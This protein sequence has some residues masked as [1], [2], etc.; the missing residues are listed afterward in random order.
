[1][2]AT[3]A[4]IDDDEIL[5]QILA[6]FS[7]AQKRGE[8]PDIEASCQK[9]P[10]LASELRGLWATAQFAAV[11][12]KTSSSN[13]TIDAPLPKPDD[14]ATFKR[15]P[16]IP[17]YEIV[18][19]L[20]RGGMG[21]V[22]LARQK[23]LNREVSLKIMRDSR[24][25][26]ESDRARFR[27]EAASAARL[28][29]PFIVTMYEVGEWQGLPYLVMEY[30]PGGTLTQRL[31]GKPLLPREAAQIVSQISRG[32]QHAHDLGVLH[33]DLKPSNILMEGLATPKISDFGLAKRLTLTA[34]SI[35]EA[36]T[37]SGAIVGTPG[38]LPPEH[39]T[40]AKTSGPTADVYGLGA[41]LY[42]CLTG[43]PPFRA[44]NP[45]DTLLMVIEQEPTPPR[46]LTPGLDRDLENICLKCLQKNPKLRYR[47]ATDLADDLEAYLAGEQVSSAQSG[48]SYFISRMLRETHHASVLENWGLLW[49]WHALATFVLCFFTQ[50]LEWQ[51]ER[52]HLT[53]LILWGVGLVTWGTILWQ[54]RRRAGPV[55]FVER[56]I[57]HAW[58]AGIAASIIMFVI[59]VLSGLEALTLSPAT[60]VAA[61]MIFL[62]K[63]GILS[64]QF[65]LSAIGMFLTAILMTIFKD[66]RILLFGASSA[67]SF[68]IPG[69]KYYRIRKRAFYNQQEPST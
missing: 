18:R 55:L 44:D 13:S 64:G 27:A 49:M 20:G 4:P 6:E 22:Y 15:M 28:K 3:S 7:E 21:V 36:R 24:L 10:K 43:V 45:V 60:A 17:D 38:Y 54:L 53:Y 56:Q 29:H 69:L 30:V 39:A 9:Y 50:F 68:F 59:E 33:R 42:E 25:G 48:L 37:L 19:E 66:V 62:F 51:G 26:S 47:D 52:N 12:A 32:V 58:A 16:E 2:S 31:E 67:L 57:A 23:S 34:E 63:A 41:I 35:P 46:V 5:A 40:G 11:F 65:Y 14:S 8:T 1:M 61:G